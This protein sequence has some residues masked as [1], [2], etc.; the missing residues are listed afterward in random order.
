MSKNLEFVRISSFIGMLFECFLP[1]SFP[2]LLCSCFFINTHQIVILGCIDF[3]LFRFLILALHS[4]ESSE[5]TEASSKHLKVK[6]SKKFVI[7]TF[8]DCKIIKLNSSR[9]FLLTLLF[10]L[11]YYII[12]TSLILLNPL[13]VYSLS[14]L[15][16][17]ASFS[18]LITLVLVFSLIIHI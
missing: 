13:Q 14:F 5:P 12:S 8:I 3:L 10:L 18:I 11:L 16:L 1:E 2:N 7:S 15:F 6:I 4:S 17:Y 9:K